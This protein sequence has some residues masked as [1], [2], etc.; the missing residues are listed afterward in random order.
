MTRR[1][2]NKKRK[3]YKQALA[4]GGEPP[5]PASITAIAAAT[6]ALTGVATGTVGIVK[7]LRKPKQPAAAKSPLAGESTELKPG[8]RV[9]AIRTAPR[10]ILEPPDTARSFLTGS[11]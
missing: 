5:D 6:T 8:Q 4:K 3:A 10:G 11:R 7:S 1:R 9:N 2:K